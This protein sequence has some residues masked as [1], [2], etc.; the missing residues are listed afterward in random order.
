MFNV[1]AVFNLPA[2]SRDLTCHC[3]ITSATFVC[4]NRT[5]PVELFGTSAT[6]AQPSG[7]AQQRF[8]LFIRFHVK[9]RNPAGRRAAIRRRCDFAKDPLFEA[10]IFLCNW[11]VNF[12]IVP[13]NRFGICCVSVQ[14][15]QSDHALAPFG[16]GRS[17]HN[18][19]PP[20]REHFH[21]RAMHTTSCTGF[22]S[23]LAL[24]ISCVE[25]N[26]NWQITQVL[27]D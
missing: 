9:V 26:R 1:T 5:S 18:S 8:E 10:R 22:V 6:P 11:D 21:D 3:Q 23:L 24:G 25:I 12:T 16:K 17:W 7:E 20:L 13:I 2:A 4:R 19:W 15:K 14:E 27:R